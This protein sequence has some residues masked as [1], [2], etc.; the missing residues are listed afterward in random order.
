MSLA[1][2][3]G[4]VAH[5]V[6][7]GGGV[8]EQGTSLAYGGL[9]FLLDLPRHIVIRDPAALVF[10]IF[11]V[12]GK[13]LVLRAQPAVDI[14]PVVE[15][16][17]AGVIEGGAVAIGVKHPKQAVQIAVDNPHSGG[18]GIRQGVGLHPGQYVELRIGRAAGKARNNNVTGEGVGVILQGV[19]VGQGVIPLRPIEHGA[20]GDVG[21]CLVHDHDNVDVLTEPWLLPGLPSGGLGLGKALWLIHGI[22]G[23]LVAE[24]V[25]KAQLVE[26]GGD[27]VGIADAEGII[28]VIAGV[29]REDQGGQHAEAEDCAHDPFRPAAAGERGR[30][31]PLCQLGLQGGEGH[32]TAG[33]QHAKAHEQRGGQ[34]H[35]GDGLHRIADVEGL[36]GAAYLPQKREVPG[37]H[38]L[39]PDLD[40]DPVGKGQRA[41]EEIHQCPAVKDIPEQEGEGQQQ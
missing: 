22:G 18:G 9:K 25:R 20:I 2:L 23:E 14:L 19:E 37:E 12:L 6:L 28:E 40:F 30:C 13:Y 35:H 15:P 27:I 34:H 7:D 3:V 10:Q 21:K 4:G 26:H 36:D 41:D 31:V 24:A 8:V 32:R 16:G 33:E 39:I 38:R 29:H 17:I 1:V 5:V 11:H